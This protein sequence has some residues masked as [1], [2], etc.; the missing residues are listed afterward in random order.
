MNATHEAQSEKPV[1]NVVQILVLNVVLTLLV[2]AGL[3]ALGLGVLASVLWAW[4]AG[5]VLTLWSAVAFVT[6]AERKSSTRLEKRQ[7][8]IAAW[9]EDARDSAWEDQSR[10]SV[11]ELGA[12]DK[13]CASSR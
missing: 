1:L 4:I 2:F 10:R 5:A 13:N 6:L 12:P 7:K 8:M 3:L 11:E 9:E